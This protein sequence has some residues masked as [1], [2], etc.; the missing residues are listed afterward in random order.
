M[1]PSGQRSATT[2][3]PISNP[4]FSHCGSNEGSQTFCMH[5]CIRP[6][7]CKFLAF[8][9]TSRGCASPDTWPSSTPAQHSCVTFHIVSRLANHRTYG[10]VRNTIGASCEKS[11]GRDVRSCT[12]WVK[13]KDSKPAGHYQPYFIKSLPFWL[14]MPWIR[15]DVTTRISTHILGLHKNV[16]NWKFHNGEKL[17]WW[18]TCRLE[19]RRR[20]DCINSTYSSQ[21]TPF[22]VSCS[23][24]NEGALSRHP[25]RLPDKIANHRVSRNL[26]VAFSHTLSPLTQCKLLCNHSASQIILPAIAFP[27]KLASAP[28]REKFVPKHRV[29]QFTTNIKTT[30]N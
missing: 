17:L 23:C 1:K 5:I 7:W 9:F 19:E 15:Q 11:V 28:D 8:T 20:R 18:F 22:T 25:H 27:P 14:A 29:T 21:H 24:R 10:H 13:T 6:T 2:T 26:E 4:G 16:S 12:F 30:Q 3:R